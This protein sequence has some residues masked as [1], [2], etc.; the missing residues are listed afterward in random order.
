[1]LCVKFAGL[2]VAE[3]ALGGAVNTRH[4]SGLRS[5]Q[6]LTGSRRGHDDRAQR[7]LC[8]AV[9]FRR[10]EQEPGLTVPDLVRGR[11]EYGQYL[12][13]ARVVCVLSRISTAHDVLY[14]LVTAVDGILRRRL[15]PPIRR[16]HLALIHHHQLRLAPALPGAPQI[17]PESCNGYIIAPPDEVIPPGFRRYLRL[18]SHDCTA[19]FLQ[20]DSTLTEQQRRCNGYD[21]T[22][23]HEHSFSTA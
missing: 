8:R 17:P 13:R 2:I 11:P 19:V 4:I 5:C 22:L 7:Y 21:D 9:L 23:T 1:M 16:A 3:R 18:T 12:I 14:I 20:A 10:L 15:H 6:R